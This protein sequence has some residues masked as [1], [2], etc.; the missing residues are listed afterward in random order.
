[1]DMALERILARDRFGHQQWQIGMNVIV[2][3]EDRK[4]REPKTLEFGGTPTF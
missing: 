4:G 2:Q 3:G 1:M